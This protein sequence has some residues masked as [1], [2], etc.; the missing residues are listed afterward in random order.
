MVALNKTTDQNTKMNQSNHT[1][2]PPT[3]HQ[4]VATPRS[5]MAIGAVLIAFAFVF[6]NAAYETALLGESTGQLTWG[7]ILFR[8][9][10]ALHGCVLIFAGWR[11]TK[12]AS[13]PPPLANITTY[14]PTSLATWCTLAALCAIAL[15]LRLH[16]LES[17]LW[18]DEIGTLVDIVREP[19]GTI[20]TSFR[21]QN[22]HMLYSL[23]AHAVIATFGESAWSLRLPAALF[24]VACIPALFFLGRRVTDTRETLLACALLTASYHHVWFSQNA[25]GYT[26]VLLFAILSTWLW[27]EALPRNDWRWWTGYVLAV[28]LGMWVHMTMAF[29]LT[30]HG[31]IYLALL[32]DSFRQK[33]DTDARPRLASRT[34]P[35]LAFILCVTI[36]TQLFAL[37]LPPFFQSGL[38]EVSLESDWINP[39]WLVVETVRGLMDG[40]SGPLIF[41][42][43]IIMICGALFLASGWF[44]YLRQDWPFAIIM[45][46]PGVLIVAVMV[47]LQHNLWPRFV[48]FC[49]GFAIL[50]VVRGA[51]VFPRIFLSLIPPLRTRLHTAS[52]LAGTT[53]IVVMVIASLMSLPRYYTLSKQDYQGAMD[54]IEQNLESGQ[55]VVSVGL[56]RVAYG[57]LYAQDKPRWFTAETADELISLRSDHTGLWV[58]YSLPIHLKE[59]H[60]DIWRMLQNDFEQIRVFPGSLR[61]GNVYVFRQRHDNPGSGTLFFKPTTPLDDLS[62]SWTTQTLTPITP[63]NC[64]S[65]NPAS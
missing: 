37:A 33:P 24:G 26:G 7:P 29:V 59:W 32:A 56:A 27:L 19:V 15:I 64:R 18:H 62:Y 13:Q 48:F 47:A 30:A 65:S 3:A 42:G 1:P 60:P 34:N 51:F 49:A 28:A 23:S 38:H 45:V 14:Q 61:D 43:A 5:L 9:L 10:L 54:Y 35:I 11:T 40:F 22:Q 57:Q 52:T 31:L 44:S 21:N 17:G 39:F 25:R 55:A 20:L 63:P 58:V 6:S 2:T 46:L 4:S 12:R 16:H 8:A 36:T 50:I 53:L 41:V